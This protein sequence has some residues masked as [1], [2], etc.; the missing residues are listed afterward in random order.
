MYGGKDVF[1]EHMV[2][3][4]PTTISRLIR[5]VV[6]PTVLLLT[7]LSLFF[8]VTASLAPFVFAGGCVGAW[9]IFIRQYVEYEY[10]LTNGEL[11]VDRITARRNRRRLLTV[12]CRRFEMLA[13]ASQAS[14]TD[15]QSIFRRVDASSW[16]KSDKCWFAVFNDKEGRRTLLIFEP[17]ERML[18]ACKPFVP[19]YKIK[20][21]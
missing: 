14:Q 17:D 4:R 3:R 1:M 19:P 11:D 5:F 6:W 20:T 8:E 9:Q 7:V 13:A 21:S 16:P 2:K 18:E 10:I 15:N 12:D